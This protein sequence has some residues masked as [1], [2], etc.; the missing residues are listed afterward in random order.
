MSTWTTH[1]TFWLRQ[2]YLS[3]LLMYSWDGHRK[4]LKNCSN[5]WYLL[6]TW[7]FLPNV[8]WLFRY[9]PKFFLSF[10]H[11]FAVINYQLQG[12]EVTEKFFLT[13]WILMAGSSFLSIFLF[14][15]SSFF[16]FL[17]LPS[18]GEMQILRIVC[19][20][21][22]NTHFPHLP[23]CRMSPMISIRGNSYEN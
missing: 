13:L 2:N 9:S 8:H 6:F 1:Y 11:S 18:C 17:F 16:F 22:N 10:H 23:I 20:E 19:M 15:F 21:D 7:S 5:L 3:V 14:F 4:L 12:H